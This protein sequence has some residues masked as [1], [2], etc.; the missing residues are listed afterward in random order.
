[1]NLKNIENKNGKNKNEK[2]SQVGSQFLT[3]YLRK[4]T[5]TA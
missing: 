4:Q 1:M 5:K 3:E 2:N